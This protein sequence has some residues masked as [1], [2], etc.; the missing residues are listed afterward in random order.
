MSKVLV[1][2]LSGIVSEERLKL[3]YEQF[4]KQGFTIE[5]FHDQNNELN[6]DSVPTII[7]FLQDQERYS[8]GIER[9]AVLSNV[10]DL[11]FSWFRLYNE[12]VNDFILVPEY[13]EVSSKLKEPYKTIIKQLA[14]FASIEKEKIRD[15][16][17]VEI[18]KEN[19]MGIFPFIMNKG[20]H[21]YF[22]SLGSFDYIDSYT[23]KKAIRK[24]Y[25]LDEYEIEVNE[26][27]VEEPI[28][29]D[30]NLVI[31]NNMEI[32]D[33]LLAS[34]SSDVQLTFYLTQFIIKSRFTTQQK[35]QILY[36]L[37][38]RIN[39]EAIKKE[40][41]ALLLTYIKE[42]NLS[43]QDKINY[44]SLIV[45]LGCNLNVLPEILH[46]LK[47]DKDFIYYHYPILT[48]TLF[49]MSKDKQ[50]SY[51]KLFQDRIEIMEKVND[52]YK[53]RIELPSLPNKKTDNDIKRIAI[54]T[55]QLLSINHAPTK[56]AIDYTNNLIK[57][58]PEL[59]VN[60]FVDDVFHYS[61]NEV[62]WTHSYASAKS[63]ELRN[64]HKN[65]LHSNITV[66]YSDS[67]LERE[68]RL[69]KDTTEM[70]KYNPDVIFKIGAPYSLATDLLYDYFPVVSMTVGGAED[71]PFVDV[72]TGGH[73]NKT[74]QQEYRTQNIYDRKY[75]QHTIGFDFPDK[76]KP[77]KRNAYKIENND[78]VMVTVGNRLEV[79]MTEEFIDIVCSFLNQSVATKW[80]IVGTKNLAYIDL[81]YKD[82]V[83][84]SKI[85]YV[86]YEK[87]LYSL[88]KICDVY[89]N[90][91]RK[92]GG[93]SGAMAMKA[94]LAV[95]SLRTPLDI[96]FFVGEEYCVSKTDFKSELERLLLDESYLKKQ[97]QLMRKRIEEKFTFRNTVN[98]L[99]GIFKL[100][101][102]IDLKDIK[103]KR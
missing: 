34:F 15:K 101:F 71:S 39:E 41:S 7:N 36:H 61:P 43:F 21:E 65:Y 72:F 11:L 85:I 51:P 75:I 102:K 28:F 53:S 4:Q 83:R 6:L 2:I 73:T 9:I 38:K 58:Y 18:D 78:F 52:Y 97:K 3:V 84:A 31:D 89:V 16:I 45:L 60:I 88:Y 66:H 48:N 99:M 30:T 33:A 47:Q 35:N 50:E 40:L 29:V 68:R 5:V 87:D 67:N 100:F 10:K 79:E 69:L 19:Y 44:Y 14:S 20:N 23:S 46:L 55:G 103:I 98:E 1:S 32:N 70:I 27:L 56:W 90:P 81:K 91:F 26:Q 96:S 64:E 12:K 59:K 8:K 74:I 24:K 17:F 62:F 22:T 25:K 80:L 49:Y 13:I 82:L 76:I 93:N 54:V 42:S 37:Y 86:P 63:S 77:K 94:G 95:V 57:Y 92:G